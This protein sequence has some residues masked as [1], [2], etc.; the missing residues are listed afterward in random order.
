MVYVAQTVDFL[1]GQTSSD[2][3]L[4][5]VSGSINY[6][7]DIKASQTA[8][9]KVHK[10]LLGPNGAWRNIQRIDTMVIIHD[11]EKDWTDPNAILTG[12]FVNS[13]PA[14][15]GQTV[16]INIAGI[17]E[18][19]R[20]HA[21]C[22]V[23]DGTI[24]DPNATYIFQG[25][26]WQNTL[27]SIIMEAHSTAGIPAGKATPPQIIRN[28]S[29]VTT[30]APT[31][32]SK[33]QDQEFPEGT[34]EVAPAN[35]KTY[36]DVLSDVRENLS[37]SGNEF[38]PKL[39][40]ANSSK[41]LV[42]YDIAIA[43]DSQPY[44]NFDQSK[45][46]RFERDG[47]L[48]G[49]VDGSKDYHVLNVELNQ[50]GGD[51]A[52]RIIAQ[53]NAGN[54]EEDAD[55]TTKTSTA[56]PKVLVD[57]FFNP[58]VKLD[59]TVLNS[60][61]TKRLNDAGRYQLNGTVTILGDPAVWNNNLG[62]KL[63]LIDTTLDPNDRMHGF[64]KNEELRISDIKVTLSESSSDAKIV[65]GFV[66]P[67]TR[68]HRLPREY[69]PEDPLNSNPN[70]NNPSKGPVVVGRAKNDP[71]FNYGGST[72]TGNPTPE[73][74]TAT[75][76]GTP[77]IADT[78]PGVL[79]PMEIPLK[80]MYEYRH[81][82]MMRE[83][84][85][86]GMNTPNNDVAGPE[87]ATVV[88]HHEGQRFYGLNYLATTL[89][90]KGH[91]KKDPTPI[92]IFMTKKN[93]DLPWDPSVTYLEGSG[94]KIDEISTDLI[95]SKLLSY[96]P[97]ETEFSRIATGAFVRGTGDDTYFVCYIHHLMIDLVGDKTRV[98]SDG[99]AFEKKVNKTTGLLEG[100]WDEAPYPFN[101]DKDE[102]YWAQP[103]QIE[104]HGNDRQFVSICTPSGYPKSS[105]MSVN[106]NST[107][108][109]QI[110]QP[111]NATYWRKIG[112]G[113][114][115]VRSIL[116]TYDY[117]KNKAAIYDG[118]SDSLFNPLNYSKDQGQ[119][120]TQYQLLAYNNELWAY[121][122]TGLA[123][124]AAKD[125]SPLQITQNGD[126][127]N[128]RLA[129]TILMKASVKADGSTGGFSRVAN[130]YGDRTVVDKPQQ[131]V[132]SFLGHN[133]YVYTGQIYNPSDPY[134]IFNWP[135]NGTI[136]RYAVLGAK[137]GTKDGFMFY[138]Y[139][140]DGKIAFSSSYGDLGFTT[141]D[142]IYNL[143]NSSG[144]KSFST[145]QYF[146]FYQFA[147]KDPSP[148]AINASYVTGH[149]T[150]WETTGGVI[151]PVWKT[152]DNSTS[153]VSY[154]GKFLA[155]DTGEKKWVLQASASASYIGLGG[156]ERDYEAGSWKWLF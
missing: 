155:V 73:P 64:G 47:D 75:D 153:Q 84:N 122:M 1:T 108:F 114:Y 104:V 3:V 93:I 102:S 112:Q 137:T 132:R 13:I 89:K 15:Y 38:M 12:G 63:T 143:N 128:A 72:P 100:N 69:R 57:T 103:A 115:S 11:D 95:K 145:E 20:L 67:A 97:T 29:G 55:F 129:F 148:E 91:D 136:D 28:V 9:V 25:S 40:W 30:A 76:D 85:I 26:T 19:W 53:S 107:D 124:S 105:L 135:K 144:G 65:V 61:M 33:E 56:G 31:L 68:Y 121:S 18:W 82:K 80:S 131:H 17:N 109:W 27:H 134:K 42:R 92:E 46:I 126:R 146:D 16:E 152:S 125:G 149:Y 118:P 110:E 141:F 127:S 87:G 32:I 156:M 140:V 154:S 147:I 86:W 81:S 41:T 21:V 8:S 49:Y 77:L 106:S 34:V 99:F 96:F 43:P 79:T 36:F 4:P 23:Y 139:S 70:G 6:S 48:S 113:R 120:E 5:H 133:G 101:A 60:E 51:Y 44:L 54:D 98:R 37:A 116:V 22:S 119:W 111:M 94:G 39:Y 130:P 7:H 35:Y 66:T 138:G 142:Y 83:Q 123:Y 90:Y 14:T 59:P 150:W 45:T 151:M 117:F 62:K 24:L 10:D 2:R 52:N 78:D 71:D 50:Q 88:A 74:P 58:N